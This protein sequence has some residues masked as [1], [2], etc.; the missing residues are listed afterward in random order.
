MRFDCCRS[1]GSASAPLFADSVRG[2][3]PGAV[4]GN[5]P[6]EYAPKKPIYFEGPI[7]LEDFLADGIQSRN[8]LDMRPSA[9][10]AKFMWPVTSRFSFV[11]ALSFAL[12]ALFMLCCQCYQSCQAQAQD[13]SPTSLSASQN[14]KIA[15]KA[16][17][18]VIK[19]L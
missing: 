12:L 4:P 8:N 2:T 15:H 10:Q 5:I 18:Q 14:V 3:I 11:S 13:K 9:S 17:R 6:E 7:S 1:A 16:E 19:S